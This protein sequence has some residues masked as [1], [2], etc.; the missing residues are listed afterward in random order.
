MKHTRLLYAFLLIPSSIFNNSSIHPHVLIAAGCL[1][2][3]WDLRP[4]LLPIVWGFNL[5]WNPIRN[6]FEFSLT[7]T[8][9]ETPSNYQ[10]I[11]TSTLS[12]HSIPRFSASNSSWGSVDL[13]VFSSFSHLGFLC[14]FWFYHGIY[15]FP[16]SSRF[17]GLILSWVNFVSCLE[18]VWL[19]I[20]ESDVAGNWGRGLDWF[21][22][23]LLV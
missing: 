18:F 16:L 9:F 1:R 11:S 22:L 8:H 7:A 10:E 6:H 15:C 21:S 14:S 2:R 13:G 19:K 17:R 23:N 5:F 20:R 12:I 3:S 4:N